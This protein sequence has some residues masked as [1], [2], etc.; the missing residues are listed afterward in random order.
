MTTN[1]QPI[2]TEAEYDAALVQIE[3]LWGAAKGTADGDRLD[4]L[5]DLVESYEAQHHPLHLPVKSPV[6]AG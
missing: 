2:R 4:E 5:V 6:G 3:L 1:T